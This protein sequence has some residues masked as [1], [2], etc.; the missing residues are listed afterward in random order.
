[1]TSEVI[2]AI[3]ARKVMYWKTR[4]KPNSGDDACSH[5]A[6]LSSMRASNRL[7]GERGDDA[8]HGHEARALDQHRGRRGRVGER[9]EQR[10]DARE[11]A[12]AGERRRG[13]RALRAHS[14]ERL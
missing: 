4:M 9:G 6:R 13:V 7:A 10:L 1:M 14:P 12:R 11:R 2:A 3:T 5:C 8:L